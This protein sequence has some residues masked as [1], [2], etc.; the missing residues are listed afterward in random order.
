MVRPVS[1]LHHL[2]TLAERVLACYDLQGAS[3]TLVSDTA[4][5]VFHVAVPSGRPQRLLETGRTSDGAEY[6]L[7]LRPPGWHRTQP[8][9]EELQWL[10]AL[11]RD[12]DLVVP[13]PV[14]ACDG[15]LI[16]AI[17]DP[18]TP[19]PWHGVLFRWVPGERRTETL[20]PPDLERVGTCMARLHQHA[21]A[22]VTAQHPPLTRHARFC[23]VRAWRHGFPPAV[24]VYAPR[25]LAVFAVAAQW[26][27]TA[28]QALEESRHGVGFI[29]ADLHQWNYLFHSEDVR[30][31]DF[32][33]CGWG[34]YIYDMA[35]TLTDL[36]DRDDCAALRHA[37]WTGYTRLQPLPP[38]YKTSIKP[39]SA[40]RI[41]FL[42]EW[43]LGRAH[44][45][46]W[47]WGEAYMRTAVG[48][49]ERLLAEATLP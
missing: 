35:V 13:E 19:G 16:Q 20:T 39:M 30:V 44:P 7:R 1:R 8:I 2:L 27:Q 47:A 43:L 15:T 42:L 45:E 22:F 28:C 23:D 41:L 9:A 21:A 3:L 6:A 46:S 33:D 40:A 31:I 26:V 14:P 5:A 48:R 18:D 12:T 36:D 32:D 37:F 29:H 4:N 10:L 49:L 38:G 11:R 34:Y 24:A 25:D 17:S